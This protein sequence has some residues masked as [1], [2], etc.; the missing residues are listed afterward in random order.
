VRDPQPLLNEP[1][2]H[3]FVWDLHHTLP[4]G[5]HRSSYLSDGPWAIPGNY[6]VKL[7]ANG[8]STAQPLTIRMDPR[9]NASAD[10]L[11]H[12]LALA[13]QL[14][15]TLGQVSI[16]LQQAEDL[17]KQIDERKKAAAG[18]SEVLAALD[19]FNQKMQLAADPGSD[20]DFILF[21]FALPDKADE[22][23]PRVQFAL[24]ALLIV[25]QSADVD[26]SADV[27]TAA[28]AWD[29]S[30]Q[31][32]L[33]RWKTVLDQDLAALNSRSQKTGLKPLLLE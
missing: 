20:D 3:R 28:K 18:K 14:S 25:E 29:A 19:N 9:S 2:M 4:E 17:R 23:L 1:G 26:P 16:A 5:L 24:T 30:S 7:T 21:G 22:P 12:Q 10:A 15:K 31:A 8:Q 27:I 11:Q 32:A 6:S 33:A 13:S